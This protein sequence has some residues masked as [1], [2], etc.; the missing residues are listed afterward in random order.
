VADALPGIPRIGGTN[1]GGE[2]PRPGGLDDRGTVR[3]R[4]HLGR[5]QGYARTGMTL[6]RHVLGLVIDTGR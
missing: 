6:D 1:M 2:S 5:E 4:H 3:T